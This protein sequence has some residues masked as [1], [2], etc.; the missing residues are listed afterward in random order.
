MPSLNMLVRDL[1]A[2]TVVGLGALPPH[3]STTGKNSALSL[4][5]AV[6]YRYANCEASIS[7]TGRLSLR[8]ADSI[9]I[10]STYVFFEDNWTTISRFDLL[11]PLIV[12]DKFSGCAWKI[13]HAGSFFV[14]AHIARPGGASADANVHLMD[15]YA[16]QK[17]WTEIQ[18]V[19]SRGVIGTGGATT[20]A[21]VTQ[22]L[23][24][25]IDT[26]RL[27]LNGMGVAVVRDRFT[28]SI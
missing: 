13:F 2:G 6:K 18:H 22:L 17:G 9:T 19:P 7:V 23:G 1:N 14:G 25:R 20:V 11:R 12:S 21:M 4:G 26:V 27:G 28:A 16:A 5:H 15:D 24:N 3:N 10:N 8:M